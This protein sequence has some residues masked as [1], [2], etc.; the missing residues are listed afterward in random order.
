MRPDG[1]VVAGAPVTV[2]HRAT[3]VERV[4]ETDGEGNYQV[5]AL[6][7]GI[8]RVE[9]QAEVSGRVVER[10]IVEVGRTVVQDFQLASATSRRR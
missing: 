8:Y 9:V 2:R 10:L 6:P 7:V 4:A 5:A 3:G 1:A